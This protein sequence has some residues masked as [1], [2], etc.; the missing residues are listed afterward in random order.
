[1][2][3]ENLLFVI[4]LLCGAVFLLA[5][6]ILHRFPP[7][8]INALYGYRTPASMKSQERWDFAQQFSARQLINFGLALMAASCLG[9]IIETT[10]TTGLVFGLGIMIVGVVLMILRIEKEIKKRFESQP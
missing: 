1:M 8:N 4:P 6:L 5:G 2:D 9:L 3:F 10:T 7:K